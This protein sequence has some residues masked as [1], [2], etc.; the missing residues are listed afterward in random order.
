MYHKRR[1]SNLAQQVAHIQVSGGLEITVGTFGCCCLALQLSK[2]LKLFLRTFRHEEG[3]EQLTNAGVSSPHPVRIKVA[4]A[5]AF[6][7]SSSFFARWYA[8]RAKPPYRIRRLTRSG[9]RTAK[10]TD[11]AHP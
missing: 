6:C 4:S 9:R 10:A 5:F 11:I 8:P 1:Y 3:R 7:N 2:F